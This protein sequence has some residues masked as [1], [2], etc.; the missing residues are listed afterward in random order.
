MSVIVPILNE[1]RE[2]PDLLASLRVL[3]GD[4][5]VVFVDGGSRDRSPA[6]VREAGYPLHACP[7]GRARQMNAGARAA[8]GDVL[9][10]LH[11]DTRLGAG[12]LAALRV[13]LRDPAVVAGQF[14]LGYETTEWPYPWI[15]RLGNAR[16]RLTKILTGDH[17]IFVRRPA[18]EAVGGYPDIPLMEDVA[19]SHRLRRLGRVACLGARV[20]GSTRKWRAEGVWRT[21]GLMW[22]LRALYA[23]GAPPAR[24]HR[25]YY[26]RDPD[27]RLPSAGV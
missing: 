7:P 3:G 22:L 20:V 6:L 4:D 24:L 19:L 15:A 10:F 2:L 8:G 11:A 21:I 23:L 12:A 16:A 17:T 14:D 5:E 1:E 26:G 18:F 13:A 9:V 25:L 27:K